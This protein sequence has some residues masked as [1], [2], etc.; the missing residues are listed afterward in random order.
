M[1]IP[2]ASHNINFPGY[3]MFW[4]ANSISSTILGWNNRRVQE[5]AHERSIEFQREMER[6]RTLTED[7]KLQEEIAFKRRMVAVARQYRQ[8][9]SAA[10][11]CTQMKVIELQTYLQ[12][13]W[14]LDPQLP[15]VFLQETEQNKGGNL[16]LNVVLLRTPLL[17]Q[18][19]FG[20][21]NDLDLEL[22]NKLEY[23]VIPHTLLF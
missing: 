11:F 23:E 18:K 22:Y 12:H 9:E 1:D 19:K 2:I 10:S 16:P 8:E 3:G 15:Y 20:G 13:C 7:K 14:P 6:A 17:P 5:K 4:V 21:A